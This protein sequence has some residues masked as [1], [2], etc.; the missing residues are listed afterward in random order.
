MVDTQDKEE[1]DQLLFSQFINM[2]F[3]TIADTPVRVGISRLVLGC[4]HS[5][6]SCCRNFGNLG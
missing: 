6:V 5:S 3:E 2:K 1:F 4:S